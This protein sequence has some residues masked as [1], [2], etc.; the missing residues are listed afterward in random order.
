MELPDESRFDFPSSFSLA[1]WFKAGEAVYSPANWPTLITKGDASWRLHFFH[2]TNRL[3]FDS[4][5]PVGNGAEQDVDKTRVAGRCDVCDGRWH[6]A[7]AVFQSDG[8]SGRKRLYIDGELEG[9][10]KTPP[11]LQTNADPVW[12][13]NGSLDAHREFCGWIDEVA[14]FARRFSGQEV[15]EMFTAGKPTGSDEPQGKNP[16]HS[17]K[18]EA[19]Q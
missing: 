2:Q 14:V 19:S 16:S 9:E 3:L 5:D 18:K 6:L 8:K 1:V 10:T 15:A 17:A 4:G 13:G 11:A 12:V 7:V